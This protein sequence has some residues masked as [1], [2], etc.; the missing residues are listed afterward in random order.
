VLTSHVG[1]LRAMDV[2]QVQLSYASGGVKG[3]ESL[4]R[5]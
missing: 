1:H 3:S 2:S 4:K 5:A